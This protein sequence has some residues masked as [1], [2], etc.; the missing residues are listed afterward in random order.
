MLPEQVKD[1]KKQDNQAVNVHRSYYKSNN[2]FSDAANP[3][4]IHKAK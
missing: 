4:S 1:N 2:I 3:T